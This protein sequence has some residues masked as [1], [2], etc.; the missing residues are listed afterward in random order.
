MIPVVG[1]LAIGAAP[2]DLPAFF[3]PSIARQEPLAE[4]IVKLAARGLK[5]AE[6]TL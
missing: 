6:N 2:T 5:K 4:V 3:G 1:F